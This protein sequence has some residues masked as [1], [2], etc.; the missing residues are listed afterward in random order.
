MDEFRQ[1]GDISN[2]VKAKQWGFYG[3]AQRNK[4]GIGHFVEEQG[5]AGERDGRYRKSSEYVVDRCGVE[6]K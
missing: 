5:K 1:N 4:Y 6:L 2:D 3:H